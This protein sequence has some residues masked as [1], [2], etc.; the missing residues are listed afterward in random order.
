[1][2]GL[3]PGNIIGYGVCLVTAA[4]ETRSPADKRKPERKKAKMKEKLLVAWLAELDRQGKTKLTVGSYCRAVEYFMS[5]SERTYGQSFDPAAIIPRDIASW[6]NY[7]QVTEKAAPATINQR[8]AAVSR[9]FKWALALGYTQSDP[10]ANIQGL[11]LA[12]RQPKA[13]GEVPLRRLL[14]E[15]HRAGNLRDTAMVEL[16][17]GAGLRVSEA[18]ALE[19][20]DITIGERSG[21][22]MVRS[23]KGSQPRTVP[24]TS[25]VRRALQNYLET[26]PLTVHGELWVGQRGPLKDPAGVY[27]MLQNYARRADID[28]SQVSPHVLRHTMATRY[29]EANPDD[30]RGLAAILGHKSLDTVMIYTMPSTDD[31]AG[32]MERAEH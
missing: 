13:L 32:R 14:R 3:A 10:T 26:L 29:L 19:R 23:G 8:L 28:E 1:M 2:V 6:K 5:W 20:D 27:R 9:F 11:R 7:Q 21:Q 31:L 12:A 25:P 16:L 22:V 30:L 24:L 4:P 15:V 17:L 18:L